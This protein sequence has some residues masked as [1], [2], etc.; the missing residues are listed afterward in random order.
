MTNGSG[1]HFRSWWVNLALVAAMMVGFVSQY[2]SFQTHVKDLEASYD[3]RFNQVEAKALSM[4][5]DI[6]V[7]LLSDARVTSQIEHISDIL[8]DL[9]AKTD[10]IL[11][12]LRSR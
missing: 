4:D 5:G 12:E 2:G 1:I 10:E 6:R 8:E 11:R 9:T 7:L 3:R